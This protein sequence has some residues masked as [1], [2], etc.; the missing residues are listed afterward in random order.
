MPS[1]AQIRGVEFLWF[2][3]ACLPDPAFHDDLHHSYRNA[4]VG[5][6]GMRPGSKV[7]NIATRKSDGT[8]TITNVVSPD[9]RL[10]L[11]IA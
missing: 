3:K 8:T 7:A 4:G 2:Q 9:V 6:S 10:R 5:E 11:R 1:G